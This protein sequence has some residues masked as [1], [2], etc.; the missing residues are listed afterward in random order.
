MPMNLN[1]IAILNR[2]GADN[3]CI[4]NRISKIELIILFKNADLSKKSG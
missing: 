3:C 2:H 4:I 1:N